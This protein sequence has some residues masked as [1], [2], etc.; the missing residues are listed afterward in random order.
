MADE[1]AQPFN[2]EALISNARER[3]PMIARQ[4]EELVRTVDPI[5]L[6]AQLT[7][8]YQSHPADETPNRDEIVRWQVKIEWLAWVV[9]ARRLSKPAQP[10]LIDAAVLEPLEQLLDAYFASA[11]MARLAPRED[12]PE[13]QREIRS[14]LELETLH[15]RGLGFRK[16]LQEFA[17]DVYSQHADWCLAN[18]G[19]T[20]QDAFEVGHCIAERYSEVLQALRLESSRIR[21]QVRTAPESATTMEGL[22]PEVREGLAAGTHELAGDDLAIAVSMI[23]LFERSTDAVGFTAEDLEARMI[24]ANMAP[25]RATALLRLLSVSDNEIGGEPNAL[26][27]T[28]LAKTPL[29]LVEGRFHLF[30]P[31]LLFEAILYAFHSRLFGDQDYR[32]TYDRKRAQWLEQQALAA[33]SA[34]IPSPDAS[35]TGLEYGTKQRR[36]DLDGLILYDGKLILIECKWKGPTLGALAGN[37]DALLRDVEKAVVEPLRQ[38][39][40]ARDF[41]MQGKE[42][43][44]VEKSSGRRIVIRSDQIT[45]VFLVTLVGSGAWGQV[46]ANLRA[47]VPLGLFSDGEFPWAVSLVDLRVVTT[48]LD[49][50]SQLFDYLRRRDRMQQDG[51]FRLHDEWDYLGAYLAGALDPDDPQF[52][53]DVDGIMLDAFDSNLQDYH[54]SLSDADVP[55]PARPRRKIPP[56]LFELL[57]S[58]EHSKVAGR[59][60]AVCTVLG[61]SDDGLL[62]LEEMLKRLRQKTIL[63]GRAHAVVATHPWKKTTVAFA[64]GHR[65]RAAI[66]ATLQSV[67][68]AKG[69]GLRGEWAGFG[70]DLASPNDLLILRGP[71]IEPSR[72]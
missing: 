71:S 18:L 70:I 61:W 42:A 32:P 17:V 39:K 16:Q 65:N 13:A 49:L 62:A 48:C 45:D 40:R 29:V 9:F 55:T 50:P 8:L 58:V 47:F 19:L 14:S 1:G 68:A 41:G 20:I 59:S 46:A 69:D 31:G 51:R 64:C 10:R 6:L 25:G 72:Q 33:F 35:G 63:D 26:A 2:L 44:F 54:Y 53:A 23:W 5:Q 30:V 52:P 38:A 60:E 34:V 28:P 15:G 36:F 67:F 37:V 24:G 4:V 43:S 3:L 12:V 7:L 22:P 66:R 57:Q 56:V 11:S 27:Q 21:E